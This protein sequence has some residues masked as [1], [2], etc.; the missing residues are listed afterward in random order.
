MTMRST[1]AGIFLAAGLVAGTAALASAQ[2]D[3]P[4]APP[5]RSQ[6]GVG[7]RGERMT[8]RDGK[9]RRR[10][11]RKH[12]TGL[13]GLRRQLDLTDAQREQLRALRQSGRGADE[14]ERAELRELRRLRRQGGTLSPE[15]QARAQALREQ[16]RASGEAR[17]QQFLSVLTPEQR[18]QL[19]Q[20]RSEMRGRREERRQRRE[21]FRQRRTEQTPQP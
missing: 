5:G 2:E 6:D 21:E 15:Q 1:L 3:R 19:E 14:D 12:R 7:R 4:A 17:R 13:R 18:A 16:L 9:A 10:M 8:R 11:A 20:Q